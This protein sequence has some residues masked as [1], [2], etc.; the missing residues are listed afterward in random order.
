MIGEIVIEDD[1]LNQI[2]EDRL[3]KML[4]CEAFETDERWLIYDDEEVE[5]QTEVSELVFDYLLE[6]VIS[7][8]ANIKS[9]KKIKKFKSVSIAK[10]S[11][12]R[13]PTDSSMQHLEDM[14]NHM[15]EIVIDADFGYRGEN[16]EGFN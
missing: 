14:S 3:I 11:E 9:G 13:L 15:E 10:F 2:K 6:E 8:L 7:D 16:I 1:Y 5:V 12:K 4:T